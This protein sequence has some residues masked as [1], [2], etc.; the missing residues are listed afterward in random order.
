MFGL[1][2]ENGLA[3]DAA[4]QDAHLVLRRAAPTLVAED[5]HLVYRDGNV[6]TKALEGVNLRVANGEFLCILGPSG[7]GKTSLLRVLSGLVRPT[8]GRVYLD[9]ELLTRP[10]R[11]VGL[12]FQAANLMPWR[13]VLRN[14]T[15]PLEVAGI[16]LA[17]AERRARA[18]LD[19]VGLAGFEQAHPAQLSGGMQQRVAIARAL[20]QDPVVLLMDEPFGAL[21]ALTRERLSLEFLR[22]WSTRRQTVVMV[23]HDIQEAIFLADRVLVLSPRPGRVVLEMAVPLPRPRT[24]DVLYTSEFAALAREARGAIAQ[25]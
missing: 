20:V 21:D 16:P 23:T 9:N 18:L 6:P 8:Q 14:V 25:A 7:C 19:L 3:V 11:R 15:L 12:V 1:R 17:E 2:R 24:L 22:I 10:S 13:T 5:I 4:A